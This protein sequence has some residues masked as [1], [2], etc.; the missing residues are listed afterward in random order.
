MLLKNVVEIEQKDFGVLKVLNCYCLLSYRT[1]TKCLKL[2]PLKF[3]LILFD[4]RQR[5][6]SSLFTNEAA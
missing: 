1:C 2:L 5:C 3:V 4:E 6:E